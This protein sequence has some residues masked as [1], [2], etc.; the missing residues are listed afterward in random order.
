MV[1]NMFVGISTSWSKFCLH[2]RS[3]TIPNIPNR[4][5]SQPQSRKQSNNLIKIL[6][7]KK[8]LYSSKGLSP[9][10]YLYIEVTHC[11]SHL[12]R[13]AI[14]PVP[15]CVSKLCS[16]LWPENA[17]HD[18]WIFKSNEKPN[19]TISPGRDEHKK[20]WKPGHLKHSTKTCR[21][22]LWKPWSMAEAKWPMK[23]NIQKNWKLEVLLTEEILRTSEV[24]ME[25]FL[26]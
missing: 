25:N 8:Q 19:W 26:F 13:G 16:A 18:W 11:L 23:C 3:P 21:L 9:K 20:Y 24:V 15:C 22:S 6:L 10:N 14:A 2:L 5:P 1:W 7:G 17:S 12:R 4:L